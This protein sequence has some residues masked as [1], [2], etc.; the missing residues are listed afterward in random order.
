MADLALK[1]V[2][3]DLKAACLGYYCLLCFDGEKLAVQKANATRLRAACGRDKTCRFQVLVS[4]KTRTGTYSIS[5]LIKTHSCISAAVRKREAATSLPYL[6]SPARL[7][8]L[9]AP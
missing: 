7:G 5:I 2:F 9:T 3:P 8:L 4:Y 6:I 1:Q